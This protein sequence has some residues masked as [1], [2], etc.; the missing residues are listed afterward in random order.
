VHFVD[1]LF[2]GRYGSEDA[3]S[4]TGER[5]DE[6]WRAA[7]GAEDFA[8]DCDVL[9][10]ICLIDDSAGPE[11]G[12]H[13]LFGEDLSGV[14]YEYEEGFDSFPGGMEGFSVAKK[15]LSSSVQAVRSEAVCSPDYHELTSI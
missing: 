9:G 3:V 8:N 5:F 14:F 2:Y 4:G 13:F 7:G 12:H 10:E 15:D 1:L 6:A 11:S